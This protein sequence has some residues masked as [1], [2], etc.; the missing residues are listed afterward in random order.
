M[1]KLSIDI[2]K[3]KHVQAS[4]DYK[5]LLVRLSGE[6]TVVCSFNHVQ[7]VE[8]FKLVDDLEN[9]LDILKGAQV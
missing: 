4:Q 7:I 8:A 5:R 9:T 3:E 2:L 1:I 6:D